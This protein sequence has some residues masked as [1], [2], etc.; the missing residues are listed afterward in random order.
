LSCRFCKSKKAIDILNLGKIP[1]S[2]NFIKKNQITKIKK[3]DLKIFICPKCLLVQTK[4]VVNKNIIFNKNYLYHSSFSRSWLEHSKNLTLDLIKE[5]NLDKSTF[6]LEIASNDGYLLNF[7]KK[8]KIP[9]IGIEPSASVA[10]IAKK[11]GIETYINFFNNNLAKKLIKKNLTPKIIIALNVLAH[12]PELVNFIKGIKI[13]I[14]NNGVGIIEFPHLLN[15]IKKFQFDTIYHEHFSY[16]SL[17][18]VINL[19]KKYDMDIFFCKRIL[20]HGGSLRI[21]IKDVSNKY[22]K[23]KKKVYQILSV[24][25]KMG[26]NKLSF[27][28]NLEKKIDRIKKKNKSKI[29]FL[30]KTKKI[31]G[32]GAAAKSTIFCN[33]LKLDVNHIKFVVD[34][35]KFKLNRCIP[36]TQ[37]PILDIKN[38]KKIKPDY[39][40]IFPWNLKKE[41][42]NQ[43]N[44]TKKWNCKFIVCDP[45]IRVIK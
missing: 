20:T 14:K 42:L 36:G 39:I 33:S 4:D 8:K 40:L 13:L 11:K 44:F 15:L 12:T 9:C 28:K 7:F 19:F 5:F 38:I 6:V 30:S 3:Y 29:E 2:N 34:K 24:E 25:K 22:Y 10:R 1:L 23:I 37:I 41:I 27:Y 35:N 45:L 26:I 21:Y 16:F 18:S 43:L 32:Y 17:H 31:I